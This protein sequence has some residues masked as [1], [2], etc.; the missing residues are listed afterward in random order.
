MLGFLFCSTRIFFVKNSS[1]A[2]QNQRAKKQNQNHLTHF[3]HHCNLSVAAHAS[4]DA[5]LS[6]LRFV[7]NVFNK[8]PLILWWCVKQFITQ[9]V[10][11]PQVQRANANGKT[12]REMPRRAHEF[13]T[14]L[15]SDFEKLLS[16]L[17]ALCRKKRKAT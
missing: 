14:K 3:T 1:R 12:N 2:M 6:V 16:A 5:A 7:L 13:L 8:K 17:F 11:K 9:A 10:K 15:R 4:N